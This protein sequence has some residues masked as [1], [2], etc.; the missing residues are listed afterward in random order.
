MELLKNFWNDETGQGLTE[1][2]S[3]IA[4]VSLGLL[5]VLVAF[6]D[7]LGRIFEAMTTELE[8]VAN[9]GIEDAGTGTGGTGGT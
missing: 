1:Y 3:I 9:P 6:R 8:T 4:L 5:V 2:A 7:E